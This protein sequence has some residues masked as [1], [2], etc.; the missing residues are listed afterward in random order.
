MIHYIAAHCP[1][2]CRY[3]FLAT[4]PEIVEQPS[5]VLAFVGGDIT[6]PFS[7]EGYPYPVFSWKEDDMEIILQ[8]SMFIVCANTIQGIVEFLLI[9]FGN[10]NANISFLIIIVCKINFFPSYT[11]SLTLLIK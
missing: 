5:D 6:L 8:S 10:K 1:L 11:F 2:Y 3:D 9:V 7:C 4:F